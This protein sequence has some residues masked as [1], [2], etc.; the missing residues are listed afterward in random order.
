M[1]CKKSMKMELTMEH[2]MVSAGEV[3]WICFSAVI[4]PMHSPATVDK[5]Q[6]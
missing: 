3:R 6:V 2:D 5:P 4:F 1:D